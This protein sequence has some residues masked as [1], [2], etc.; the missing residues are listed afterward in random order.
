MW[1]ADFAWGHFKQDEN[2]F[3]CF[4]QHRSERARDNVA[5]PRTSTCLLGE[6]EQLA[7]ALPL[8]S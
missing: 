1:G 5:K 2:D 7:H 3:E 6:D 4:C 8:Q